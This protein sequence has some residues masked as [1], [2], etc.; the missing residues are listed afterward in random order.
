ME[1]TQNP[2]QRQTKSQTFLS[3][4]FT[5]TD[6]TVLCKQAW[7]QCH[8]KVPL[9]WEGCITSNKGW[10]PWFS[11]RQDGPNSLHGRAAAPK[12]KKRLPRP[13]IRKLHHKSPKPL[14]LVLISVL[15]WPFSSLIPEAHRVDLQYCVN[16]AFTIVLTPASS[17]G[18][19][20]RNNGVNH[21][22]CNRVRCNVNHGERQKHTSE[23]NC[24][25]TNFQRSSRVKIVPLT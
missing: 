2:H 7:W 17:V 22:R 24:T 12:K 9:H 4:K 13:S 11:F 5:S 21:V 16:D 14:Q 15:S 10:P 3:S 23:G 18:A 20:I 19:F 25:D 6:N 1:F 8:S